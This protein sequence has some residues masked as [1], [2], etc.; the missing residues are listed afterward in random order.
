MILFAACSVAW[1][2]TAPVHRALA[3]ARASA[4][5][6]AVDTGVGKDASLEAEFES[7]KAASKVA[8]DLAPSL[9]EMTTPARRRKRDAIYGAWR[10]AKSLVGLKKELDAAAAELTAD[11]CEIDEPE[12]CEEATGAVRGLIARTF[13]SSGRTSSVIMYPR[14]SASTSL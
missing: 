7:V 3:P 10:R 1:Q 9:E 14:T 4:P 13:G 2:P 8:A 12:V 6:L 11:E 5:R